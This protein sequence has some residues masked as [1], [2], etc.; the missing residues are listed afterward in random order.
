LIAAETIHPLLLQPVTFK[1][2][3]CNFHPG[4]AAVAIGASEM[5]GFEL[6]VITESQQRD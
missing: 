2:R 1:R 5:S 3:F 4:F 6:F